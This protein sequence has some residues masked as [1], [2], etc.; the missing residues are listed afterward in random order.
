MRER[1]LPEQHDNTKYK[2][3]TFPNIGFQLYS[4]SNIA[5]RQSKNLTTIKNYQHVRLP[6]DPKPNTLHLPNP[7]RH[8]N[9]HYSRRAQSP[10]QSAKDRH[11]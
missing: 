9:Q 7:Q 8:K 6:P 2:S 1:F 5:N 3:N 10:L 11:V 4:N